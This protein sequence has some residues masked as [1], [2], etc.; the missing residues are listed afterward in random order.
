[1]SVASFLAPARERLRGFAWRPVAFAV[2][3]AGAIAFA[4]TPEGAGRA[5]TAALVRAL[6]E[7]FL[8]VT[9][10]SWIHAVQQAVIPARTQSYGAL[11]RASVRGEPSDLF[12]VRTRLSPEGALV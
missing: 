1:M 8:S 7:S 10:V 9:D 6:A 2:L 4:A 12:L 11:V 3:L 5:L